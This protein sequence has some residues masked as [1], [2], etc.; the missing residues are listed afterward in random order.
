MTV[1]ADYTEDQA[2]DVTVTRSPEQ[3]ARLILEKAPL[4]MRLQMVGVW[5]ALGIPLAP[6]WSKN[7]VLGWRIVRNDPDEIVLGVHA[8]LGLAAR[9]TF[10]VEP[11]RVVQTMTVRF[12]R[13][14]ARAVWVRLAPG[15]R[16]FV[17]RLLRLAG[18]AQ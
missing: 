13:A 12:D 11:G 14:P 8:L 3:W 7:Q 10:R 18:S 2:V 9:L 16:R 4:T 1:R 5:T 17:G 6:P 15:H